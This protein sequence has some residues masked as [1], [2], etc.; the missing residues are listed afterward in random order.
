MRRKFTAASWSIT[1]P[2]GAIGRINGDAPQG[3]RNSR[4]DR[5][6]DRLAESQHSRVCRFVSG[7]V[8]KKLGL[9]VESPKSEAG[10]DV[11]H[12]QLV[13]H[14]PRSRLG[15]RLMRSI[16][17]VSHTGHKRKC[18]AAGAMSSLGAASGPR[19]LTFREAEYA[20][21]FFIYTRCAELA[22]QFL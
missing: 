18:D 2:S 6:G 11:A 9:K 20:H 8:T 1:K 21:S 12:R 4:R 17:A 5:Q 16:F 13:E 3:K 19:L 14:L 10:E 15:R 7:H 22:G